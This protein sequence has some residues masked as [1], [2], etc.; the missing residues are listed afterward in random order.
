MKKNIVKLS[1]LSLI[2]LFT[3]SIYASDEIKDIGEVKD[4]PV[5]DAIKIV[6]KEDTIKGGDKLKDSYHDEKVSLSTID[7][8]Y[9]IERD[10]LYFPPYRCLIYHSN[11]KIT[12]IGIMNDS[13]IN[14]KIPKSLLSVGDIIVVTN[15]L[16]VRGNPF[17]QFLVEEIE[18]LK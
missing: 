3:E 5:D 1:F 8:V 7:K 6:V 12:E 16:V 2:F 13:K 11:E 4:R 18:I 10:N 15:K 9:Q 14:F 17:G